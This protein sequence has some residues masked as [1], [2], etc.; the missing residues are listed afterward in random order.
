MYDDEQ[1]FAKIIRGEMP[2]FKV[3]EDERALAFMDAMPQ[4]DG[5]TLVVPKTQ[6]RNF[7]D[8]EP[9]RARRADQGDAA[10]RARRAARRSI[11]AACASCSSTKP[12]RARRSSTSISTSFPATKA[13]RCASHSRDWADKAV[14]GRSTPSASGRRSQQAAETPMSQKIYKVPEDFAALAHLQA[15]PTTSACTRNRCAIRTVS[16]R[17]SAG[18]STGSSRTRRSRTPASTS[19]DFRIRWYYDGKLN[20]AA[21]CLD[22]HLAKRGDKTAIIWE[23]DDPRLSERITYRQLY[24]RVCQCANALQV[25]RRA[26]RAIASR[27]TCR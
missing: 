13:C 20:V 8:I 5:H 22:R 1:M 17:A 18:A 26:A 23:G 15:R 10:R 9:A 7:F 19:S 3:Y 4:S 24:E 2:A 6:A 21:N 12:P 14:L 27:S 11:P 16:G 25:A